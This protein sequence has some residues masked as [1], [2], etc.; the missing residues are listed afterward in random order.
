MPDLQLAHGL[1]FADLYGADGLARIDGLFLA[2]LAAAD[3]E[4]TERRGGARRGSRPVA[5]P[6]GA[7]P[8]P[9]GASAGRGG[10]VRRPGTGIGAWGVVRRAVQRARFRAPRHGL[11]RRR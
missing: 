6:G 11:A 2:A 3:A 10:G 9:E 8:R 1:A 7:A 4:L 5:G